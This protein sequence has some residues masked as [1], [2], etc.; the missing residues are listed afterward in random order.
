MRERWPLIVFAVLV[1]DVPFIPGVPPFWIVLLD[2]IGLSAL[3]AMGLVLL[4]G[5]GGL[6]SFGQA[7]FV[8]FGAYTTAVLS[9]NYG[10]SPWLTL[11]LSLLVSGLAAVLLGLVTV[12]LSGHYLP[13][14]TLA[15]GLGLYYLFSK[16]AFLGRN[17]GISGIPPLSI[18]SLRML[19]P[20][21]IY[22]AI[23]AA[24]LI[25]ALLTMNLLDSRTGRAI[26]ALRR[27]HIAAEAFGVY[28][29]RA[30]LLVFIYAAVLAGLSG[31]LYAHFARAVNPTP[32][33]AQAGIEYLFVAVVGG[34][35]YVWGG[36][37]GAAIVVIL[38]E[39]LQSYLPLLLHG[40]GQLET[41]VFGILLVTLLQLAPT[42]L[43][44]WLTARLPFKPVAK[45]PDT[46]LEL[47]ARVRSSSAPNVLLQVDN[48]R[49]QFGGVV[50]V[51][52]V[53]FDVQ[54][55][56][57]VA[58]IGPNGAGKS[59]TF[60]LITGVLP[61]TSGNISVLGKAVGNAPPQ[62]VVKLGIS[63]TFQ[64]VK[65]VP[66]MTVLEN[67]AIGAHLRGHSGA[68]SSMFRLD[69]ADEAKLLAEAA[70]QIERVGLGD[71]MHQLAG[72]LS[73]GQQRIVEIARALCV[74]PML[75]LLDEPAAGLRH[76]EK[77]RLGALLRELRA[78][79]MSVLLVEHDMGFVMDLAD[80][81]VV[82]DFGTKIAE[83]TPAAIKTNPEVI[84]A[85]LGAA[86]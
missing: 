69:R 2:N 15:W 64:H 77:Q 83:G 3:V 61:P 16:L 1:A 21:T 26:R 14:G 30:K 52:N 74:D 81:I 78:G 40:E 28:S 85:Y 6:T 12:R 57:I 58:L 38:K 33:G 11:P 44:P 22:Y 47:P 80:R 65:L 75:L 49:K 67:V 31:W 25:S 86:A 70:R 46:S 82:L 18:G 37:L 34:A 68:L 76:M 66:D 5:V 13:L 4:T 51:N 79:G 19:D 7:A 84:K 53:S 20:G 71:Q 8:G 54:A 72:S 35:G 42:G 55:R 50:A 56:E 39:V 17:D 9:A 24:V 48:A 10:V 73:L 32:F 43:W 27:G 41:I 59:T 60:N 63:R 62:D 23:W 29:P 36:V 45:K